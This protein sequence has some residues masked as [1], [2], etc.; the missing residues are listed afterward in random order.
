MYHQVSTNIIQQCAYHPR[1][2]GKGHTMVRYLGEQ[3]VYRERNTTCCT[4][5][6]TKIA[7]TE[8]GYPR[9]YLKRLRQNKCCVPIRVSINQ[10]GQER[11][12]PHDLPLASIEI[13][14]TLLM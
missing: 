12:M 9:T 3:H 7:C 8:R 13:L 11:S 2:Y 6:L 14:E 4:A 1:A 5:R 10:R